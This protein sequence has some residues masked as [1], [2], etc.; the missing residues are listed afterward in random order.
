MSKRLKIID[1]SEK[2][3]KERNEGNITMVIKL[4]KDAKRERNEYLL[5]KVDSALSY[6]QKAYE[7][8]LEIKKSLE[9]ANYR[10]TAP[11]CE[12]KVYESSTENQPHENNI[13]NDSHSPMV[14]IK[15]EYDYIDYFS[16]QEEMEEGQSPPIDV[17]I[18]EDKIAPEDLWMMKNKAE[19]FDNKM[20]IELGESS[21]VFINSLALR[22]IT[23]RAQSA[24]ILA[25]GIMC[26]LFIS[27]ALRKASL[28]GKASDEEDRKRPRLPTI[29]VEVMLKFV[30]SH[31]RKFDWKLTTDVS[32]RNSLRDKL[33]ELR[34]KTKLTK[35]KS[36]V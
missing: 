21:G 18:K 4:E 20:V 16:L 6:A 12:R 36:T 2:Y 1:D 34:K 30:R 15:E 32:I 5:A 29:A 8:L 19:N 23:S 26:E 3:N 9:E 25:R 24:N 10:E 27:E 11:E 14:V 33:K 7:E 28:D 35:S 13:Q 31:A 22:R 17:L